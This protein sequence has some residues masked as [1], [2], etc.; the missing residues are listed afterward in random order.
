MI[1]LFGRLSFPGRLSDIVPLA[2]IAGP[3]RLLA[4]GDIRYPA[5]DGYRVAFLSPISFVYADA[6]AERIEG[7]EAGG[8]LYVPGCIG[9]RI[10]SATL[11]A[12]RGSLSAEFTLGLG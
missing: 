11:L 8:K 7:E 2:C 5:R 9:A 10:C 1:L 3:P 12:D 4:N 6:D